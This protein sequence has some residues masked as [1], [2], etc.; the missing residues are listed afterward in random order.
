MLVKERCQRRAVVAA[1]LLDRNG[2]VA[3]R[4]GQEGP[5]AHYPRAG[6]QPLPEK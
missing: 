2:R 5:R 1:E 3:G 4:L 6:Q